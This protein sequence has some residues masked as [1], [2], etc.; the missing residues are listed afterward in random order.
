MRKL[1]IIFFCLLG[2][3]TA[4][5]QISMTVSSKAVLDPEDADAIS[6]FRQT[7]ANDDVCAIIK[8]SP[9][10]SLS[11]RL[12]LQTRGGMAPVAPP[13]GGSNYRDDSGEWWFWISPKVTNIM[14]TCEGYTSTDWIGVSLQ[15]GKVYRLSL[16]VESTYTIV[17]QF[18]GAGLSGIKMT[19]SP[20]EAMVSYGTSRDQMINFVPVTDGYFDASLPEGTYYFKIESEFYETFETQITIGKG[21]KEA[22]VELVPS[23]GYLSLSSDPIGADVY[24][25]GKRIG[26]TPIVKSDRISKGA[27]TLVFRKADYYVAERKFNVNGDGTVQSVPMAELKPQFGTV[28]ILCDDPEAELIVIDPSGKEVFRGS[29][30]ESVRLNSQATYKLEASKPSHISQSRGIVGKTIEG[31]NVEIRVDVPV[32]IYGGLQISSIPSRAEVYIDGLYAGTTLFAQALIVGLHVVEL[33]KEGYVPQRRTVEIERDH[34]SSLSFELQQDGAT[35]V[36]K[37]ESKPVETKPKTRKATKPAFHVF[38]GA[39]LMGGALAGYDP[40]VKVL[41]YGA[42]LGVAGKFGGY[43]KFRGSSSPQKINSNYYYRASTGYEYWAQDDSKTGSIWTHSG[44]ETW[45]TR[46]I[47]TAGGLLRLDE[48]FY[49]YAGGGYGWMQTYWPSDSGNSPHVYYVLVK[50]L[51]R[52]GLT[53]EAGGMLRFGPVGLSLGVADTQGYVDGEAGLILFF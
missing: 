6:Y 14:F 27:H 25:D 2:C 4:F 23:F 31:K 26:S 51:S 22:N 18:S 9:D 45:R 52:I 8:V 3:L 36:V 43:L 17:K 10:N 42:M 20:E 33:R 21:M 1:L 7:D 29:S 44:S 34:T 19:I 16:S 37:Q 48:H 50:D 32:P 38:R 13:N 46:W 47:F 30:G 49:L 40:T 53:L 15:P 24:L 11:S 12:V 39:D 28:T 35:K 5:G 41:S